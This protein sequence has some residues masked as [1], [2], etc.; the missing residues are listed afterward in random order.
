M[1][2]ELENNGVSIDPSI[3][4]QVRQASFRRVLDSKVYVLSNRVGTS[5]FIQPA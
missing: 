2:D 4:A 5:F 1:A 3:Y